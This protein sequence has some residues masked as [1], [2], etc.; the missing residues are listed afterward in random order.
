MIASAERKIQKV[1]RKWN[2]CNDDSDTK[3]I[4]YEMWRDYILYEYCTQIVLLLL[5]EIGTPK[6]LLQKR[7]KKLIFM[8]THLLDQFIYSVSIW[9]DIWR[10]IEC[11][12]VEEELIKNVCVYGL[13]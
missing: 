6:G 12:N 7:K 1:Q 13:F 2:A 9:V 10:Y 5:A 3:K 11:E 4:N 8:M